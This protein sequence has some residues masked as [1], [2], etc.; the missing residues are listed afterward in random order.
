VKRKVWL[1][2]PDGEREAIEAK[3][4][5][6]DQAVAKAWQHWL[7]ACEA[8]RDSIRENSALTAGRGVVEITVEFDGTRAPVITYPSNCYSDV[9]VRSEAKLIAEAWALAKNE[10]ARA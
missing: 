4:Q 2:R 5:Q 7:F 3:I 1:R 9:P 8:R 10:E 6:L